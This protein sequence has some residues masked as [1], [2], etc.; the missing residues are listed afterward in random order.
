VTDK[1]LSIP[2]ERFFVNIAEHGNTVSSTIP[3]ALRDAY[4]Q[5]L[6]RPRD[7]VLL[8]GYGVGLSWGATLVRFPG[9]I[10]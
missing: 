7:T 6:I 10:S 8:S 2:P 4:A 1:S 5:G 9:A 3:I